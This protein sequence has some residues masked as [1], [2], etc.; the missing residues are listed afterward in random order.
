MDWLDIADAASYAAAPS[1]EKWS[2]ESDGL[3][4]RVVDAHRTGFI[5]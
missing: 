5:A 1:P 3:T 2:D 4:C